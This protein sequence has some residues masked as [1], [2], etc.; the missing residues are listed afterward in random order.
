M[1]DDS[2]KPTVTLHEMRNIIPGFQNEQ[3]FADIGLT[4]RHHLL[5]ARH[6][7]L[8][9]PSIINPSYL[10]LCL[11]LDGLGEV[12]RHDDEGGWEHGPA[13]PGRLIIN[14]SDVNLAWRW[15]RLDMVFV[16]LRSD[17][18][19]QAAAELSDV[20][21]SKLKLFYRFLIHDPLVETL[22]RSFYQELQSSQG[23]GALFISHAVQLLTIHLLRHY[24]TIND[25]LTV[26]KG[27]LPPHVLKRT[28]ECLRSHLD[29]DF[30]L[31]TLATDAKLSPYHFARQFKTSVGEAP[32][33]YLMR[34]RVEQ[35][36]QLLKTTDKPIAEIALTI[37]YSSQAHFTTAFKKFTGI[38]PARFRRDV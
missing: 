20:D 15:D 35:A 29:Q 30:S 38:T 12:H 13:I 8:Q 16:Y 21:S 24:S 17:T 28:L 32:Y 6:D 11:L 1:N 37:G 34:L 10:E 19:A 25:K 23:Y 7:V 31:E 33:R 5:P 18:L 9:V 36:K 22:I 14:P 26:D 3:A 27:G 4:V 2:P